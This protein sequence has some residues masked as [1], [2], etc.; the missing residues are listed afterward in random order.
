MKR[1]FIIFLFFCGF[2]FAQQTGNLEGVVKDA[3]TGEFL[4]GVNIILKGTYYGAATNTDGKFRI[5]NIT[6][7]DYNVVV[8]LIGYKPTDIRQ[9]V[10]KQIEQNRWR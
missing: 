3:K 8:S 1:F 9:S 7:G 10:L 4:P 6:V 2:S 5:N